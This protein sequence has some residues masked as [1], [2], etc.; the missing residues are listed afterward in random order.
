MD[1]R[2]GGRNADIQGIHECGYA[3]DL[4]RE[5]VFS[6]VNFTSELSEC[7]QLGFRCQKEFRAASARF[8][9]FC[10][11]LSTGKQTGK[12]GALHM[13]ERIRHSWNNRDMMKQLEW[14]LCSNGR[15]QACQER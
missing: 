2:L 9:S 15:I 1:I 6:L 13:P 12:A 3:C 14:P 5:H 11:I 8:G 7:T 4:E 10:I